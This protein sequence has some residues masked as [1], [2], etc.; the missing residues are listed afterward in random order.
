[1]MRIPGVTYLWGLVVN[2]FLFFILF[3]RKKKKLIA[4]QK[5]YEVERKKLEYLHQLQLEKHE[6]EQKHE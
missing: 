5:K 2:K 6:E 4:Q 1:M 3:L